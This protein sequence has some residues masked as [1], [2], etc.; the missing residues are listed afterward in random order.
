MKLKEILKSAN[1]RLVE[2]I[3]E[4]K[5][6]KRIPESSFP[7]M[8]CQCYAVCATDRCTYFNIDGHGFFKGIK[9]SSCEVVQDISTHKA[10]KSSKEI[11]IWQKGVD[12]FPAQ[13]LYSLPF[14]R[15]D[16]VW[17]I[18]ETFEANNRQ[19]MAEF[20]EEMKEIN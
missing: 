19:N 8:H 18:M 9:L 2:P 15:E 4:L 5:Q 6:V 3:A 20:S 7:L 17:A 1:E 12:R 11:Q 16:D 10:V 13:Y 14:D